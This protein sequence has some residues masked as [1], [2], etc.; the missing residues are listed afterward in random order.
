MPNDADNS[1]SIIGGAFFAEL[2]KRPAMSR[3]PFFE[4]EISSLHQELN[5]HQ[6]QKHGP[7]IHY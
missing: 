3:P 4:V 2:M 1:P 7:D 6:D 5:S